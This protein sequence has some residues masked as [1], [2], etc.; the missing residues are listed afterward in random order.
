LGIAQTLATAQG[1]ELLLLQVL[2]PTTWARAA[3]AEEAI[4]VDIYVQIQEEAQSGAQA[5]LA[6][7]E[8]RV[9]AAGGRVRSAVLEGPPSATLLDY[10]AQERADLLVMATHGR[11]GLA[12]FALGSVT[13]RM[14]REGTAPVLVIRRSAAVEHPLER[15]LVMLDGSSLSEEALPLVEALAGKPLRSATL[16]RA[17]RDPQNHAAAV[18]YLEGHASKLAREGFTVDIRAE[19]GEP[20]QLVER[21]AQEYDLVVV[22]THGRGGFDRLRHGSVAEHVTREIDKPALLV[23]AGMQTG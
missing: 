13:D 17:V 23:R 4:A 8:A 20:R 22:C 6:E 16:F 10:E 18:A 7:L 21:I 14:I 15:A 2:D 3:T 5:H 1:A 19:D 11:S 9:R 12:R